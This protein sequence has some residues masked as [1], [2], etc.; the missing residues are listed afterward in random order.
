MSLSLE[1]RN[2]IREAFRNKF[3]SDGVYVFR[4]IIKVNPGNIV[5][6]LRFET[7]PDDC[8][9]MNA[10]Y[11]VKPTDIPKCTETLHETFGCVV[12]KSAMREEDR[13]VYGKQIYLHKSKC[14]EVN[15]FNEKVSDI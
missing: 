1:L 14:F 4:R 10:S 8:Y 13:R 9:P 7:G 2:T 15:L 12:A 11:T 6:S 5:S 3:T